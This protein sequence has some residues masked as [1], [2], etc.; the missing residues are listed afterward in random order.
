MS[1]ALG[2]GFAIQAVE[3]LVSVVGRHSRRALP[4]RASAR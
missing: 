4:R 1:E 2:V 3:T